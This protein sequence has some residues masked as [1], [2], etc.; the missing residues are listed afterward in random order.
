MVVGSSQLVVG[1]SQQSTVN[2]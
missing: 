2:S 1:S